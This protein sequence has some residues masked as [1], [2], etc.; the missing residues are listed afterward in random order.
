MAQRKRILIT[1]LTL[2]LCGAAPASAQKQGGVLKVFFF[3]S[4]ASSLLSTRSLAAAAPSQ[5]GCGTP[6]VAGVPAQAR[7]LTMPSV[8]LPL[9]R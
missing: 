6:A 2:M 3:D 8:P 9:N 7:G 1:A 5:W 4:P